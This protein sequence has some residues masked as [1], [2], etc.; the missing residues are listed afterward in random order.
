MH[1]LVLASLY[2]NYDYLLRQQD[3]Q[4]IIY[5]LLMLLGFLFMAFGFSYIFAKGY[6]S[7]GLAEGFRFGLLIAVAF[8]ISYALVEYS[9]FDIP[10]SWILPWII[11]YLIQWVL[12]GL[13]VAAI[14]KPK[15]AAN[16]K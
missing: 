15:S 16:A 13:I 6:E 10:D 1:S 14:Y 7:K 8:G 4:S 9:V 5:T 11:G 3:Q 2:T 12:A